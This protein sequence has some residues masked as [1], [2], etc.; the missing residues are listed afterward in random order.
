M[1]LRESPCLIALTGDVSHSGQLLIGTQGFERRP[2]LFDHV[3]H[4]S[5]HRYLA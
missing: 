1:V 3:Q 2:I 4:A 5:D